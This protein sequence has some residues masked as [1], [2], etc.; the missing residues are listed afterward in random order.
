MTNRHIF[1]IWSV[2]Y[3]SESNRLVKTELEDAGESTEGMAVNTAK[4]QEKVMAL[5][6]IDGSGGIDILTDSGE[7]KSTYDILL[8][9]SEVWDKMNDMDQ[10]A[11]LELIAGKQRGS[12]VAGLLQNGDL[13][14]SVYESALNA[15]GSAQKELDTYLDSIQGKV[16]TLTNSMQTMWVNALDSDVVKGFLDILNIIVKLTDQAGLMNVAFGA[17]MGKIAF[18]SKHFGILQL[19]SKIPKLA[20]LASAAMATLGSSFGAVSA[21]ATAGASILAGVVLG[22]LFKLADELIVTSEEI[23]EAANQAKSAIDSISGELKNNTKFVSDNAK[24]FAELA[25]G[26]DMLSGKNMSLS[27][28]DYEEFLSLS[29]Q[30]AEIFP[31]LSR[32]YDENGNAIVQLSG[33]TNTMVSSLEN[34]LEVQRQ[35]AQQEIVDNLPDLYAGVKQQSDGYK[36]EIA[37]IESSIQHYRGILDSFSDDSVTKA[38]DALMGTGEMIY[39]GKYGKEMANNVQKVLEQ[40]GIKTMLSG[41]VDSNGNIS[42]YSLMLA[43]EYTAEQLKAAKSQISTGV[44]AV[45]AEYNGKLH[46]LNADMVQATNENKA[47]WSS[48]AG[49]IFSWL[50]TDSSYKILDDN[51]QSMVQTVINNLDYSTLDFESWDKAQKWISENIIGLFSNKDIGN[52][53]SEQLNNMFKLKSDFKAGDMGIDDYKA[54]LQEYVEFVQGLKVE[55]EVQENL[56]KMFGLDPTQ[57][58]LEKGKMH[59]GETIEE[60]KNHAKNLVTDESLLGDLTYKDL[61]ILYQVDANTTPAVNSVQALEEMIKNKKIELTTDFTVANYADYADEIESVSSSISTYQEALEKLGSGSF[62]MAD[63]VELIAKFPDLAEGVD[64]ASENFDGLASNLAKAIKNAPDDLVDELKD[65]KESLRDAGKETDAIDA[66]IDALNNM[67]DDALD[68]AISKYG[69]LIDQI[70][71]AKAA[72]E[73]LNAAMSKNPNEGFETRGKAIEQMKKLMEKDAIGSESELWD[74]AEAYGF[75]PG[76]DKT[77][78]ENAD[79]LYEFIQARES[80]FKTDKDGN[81]TYEGTEN[82][83]E[84][85]EKAIQSEEFKTALQRALDKEGDANFD[86]SDYIKWDYDNGVFDFDF[87]NANWD[88]IVQALAKTAELTGLTSDEFT[89]LLIQIGMFFDV[90]WKNTDDVSKYM[91]TVADG[92]STVEEKIDAM[93][94]A[95]EKYVEKALGKDID[96]DNLT[97][98]V[99]NGLG[100]I[101]PEIKQL[102]LDYLELKKTLEE[103]PLSIKSTI[104]KEGVDGLLKI[105][106]LLGVIKKNGDGTIAFDDAQ[107][108]ATLD[109]LGYAPDVIDAV[110]QKIKEY[111][112]LVKQPPSDPLGVNDS[113]QTTQQIMIA[114]QELGAEYKITKSELGEPLYVEANA[115]DLIQKLAENGWTPSQISSYMSQL[116]SAIEENQ[117][118]VTINGDASLQKIQ[119][120]VAAVGALE[121]T[122]PTTT[123]IVSTNADVVVPQINS[124]LD[125]IPRLITTVHRIVTEYG[126]GGYSELSNPGFGGNNGGSSG[127][128]YAKADGTA[129]VQGTAYKTGSWG[130]ENTE[131]ALVGELGPE[132]LV[133][134]G[135]WTTIGQNG[136]EFTQIKKGDIIFNHKQTE[137]LL[138][139]GYVAGRGRAYAEGTAFASGVGTNGRKSDD[140]NIELKKYIKLLNQYDQD[141]REAVNSSNEYV[142]NLDDKYKK[143]G[144]IDNTD[145]NIVFWNDE[146]REKHNAYIEDEAKQWGMNAN[147]F[148][149]QQLRNTWSTVLGTSDE[150]GFNDEKLN[151]AYSQ[152]LNT[153][154]DTML[155]TSDEIKDYIFDVMEKSLVDGKID[156]NKMIEIDAEGIEKNVQGE[157]VR[158]QNMLAG[159]EGQ[160][161]DG[162]ELTK[163]DVLAMSG[164]LADDLDSIY[165]D[166]SMHEIQANSLFG[167]YTEEFG[168]NS[169]AFLLLEELSYKYG[170]TLDDLVNKLYNLQSAI[171]ST[172]AT[173]DNTVNGVNSAIKTVYTPN[174]KQYSGWTHTS[175]GGRYAMV[176]GTAH[177]S[178]TDSLGAAKT[179]TALVGELG[180]EMIVRDGRWT[181]VG[182]NGAEFRQIKKGDIIFNHKQTE[183]LLKNGYVTGRGKAYAE[184]TAF[185]SG[186]G[187]HKENAYAF[188]DTASKFSSAAKKFSDASDEF[189]ETFDW[190]EV[191]LEE[192][193]ESIDL[194]SA[195]LENIVSAIEKNNKIDEIIALN[196]T[197]YDNLIAGSAKY[198]EYAEKI[199]AD[200]PAQYHEA[201]KDGSIDIELFKG[202]ANE[203]VLEAIEEYRDWVQKGADATQ[204]AE[205]VITEIADLAKDAFDNIVEDYENKTSL[206]DSKIDQLDA[207]NA[208]IETDLG[209]ESEKIYEAMIKETSKNI[210]ILENQR[211][212]MQAELNKRVEAGEIQKHSQHWYDAVNEISEVD[213]Q[214][215]ELTTDIEDYQD[216]INELHWDNFDNL[217]DRLEMVANEADNLIDVLSSKD[218]VDKDTAEWTDEGVATLGLYAQQMEVAEMQAKKY[219]EE[220]DYLNKN[221]KKLGYTEQEY[222]EKLDELKSGQYDAIKSYNDTKEA[223]KDLTSERVDAIKR[224][225]E[226]E[227][228]AYEELI[229]KKKEELDAEKDLHDFQK[230]VADQQKEIADIERKLAA[231]SSDNSA[232]ARAQ[233]AK[234]QAE[235]A[236]A[237]ADL[238]EQYYERSI[239]DQ[240]NALDKEL[241]NFQETK[242]KEMEGWDEYL[243]DTEKVVSDSLAVVQENTNTVYQTLQSMGQEYSLSITEALTS[244][245]ADGEKAIQ[246]YSEKFGL[247]MSSTVEELQN[248]ATEYEKVMDEID[249]YGTNVV[250][251]VNDNAQIYQG[252]SASGNSSNAN[253]SATGL[254]SSLSGN[255][256]YGDTG[257][258]VKKLQQA[259]NE[260]GYGNSGTSSVD[261][262]FGDQT[263]SAVKKFQSAM[264]ISADGIV[265]TETKKKFKLKG[266]AN[267]SKG[268]EKD[269]LALID[270]LGEELIITPSNGRVKFLKKD[271]G[272][273]PADLTSNLM[274][275]GKLDPSVMLDQNRPQIGMSP[276]AINNTTEIHIDSSVGE[277]I[278][279]ENLN[280]NNPAEMTKII[281]KAWDKRMKELNAQIRRYASR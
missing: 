266:Y 256:K 99:V 110:I 42:S 65:L 95:V 21:I 255:I 86:I 267:G 225:I 16:N 17:L 221:W 134:D 241:E 179:E 272:V 181:T 252:A 74:I 66:L 263:L 209:T 8:A 82:F 70:T 85:A 12:V 280:G 131:T 126:G 81:V 136:A 187:A 40:A 84:A 234:L 71:A 46:E 244:P 44:D 4:L 117:L 114:L 5:T 49:S 43:G 108:T 182:D 229:D 124:Y 64:A 199:L 163:E 176:N 170:M 150:F 39:D 111:N 151:I 219:K 195:K 175:G 37:S 106:E 91:Q 120:I 250:D 257:A 152:M 200:I 113:R 262:I 24:R 15:S 177:S 53:V 125:S 78:R 23:Q 1:L 147:D 228:E 201:V 218:L 231:L 68:G 90:D 115:E 54:K 237:Q 101:D 217:I 89:D 47:N 191:R 48:L 133:R 222:V 202:E 232:S 146:A 141:V 149:D 20:N 109:K 36:Q 118:N 140:I 80:W 275:W 50:Q 69:S 55:P 172:D 161:V 248:L 276:S 41:I 127:G 143:Y 3:L 135:R 215:I 235:L 204:Q 79:A 220:I 281:D 185:V 121:E 35:L 239:Q 214:I 103:D 258:N 158:V 62:T 260:L 261:G 251:Q 129:H 94:K 2:A 157:I 10:A 33:D 242:D 269:Q 189:E 164:D 178:G 30:L 72:Q 32:N 194:N 88:A 7:F 192:I 167:R 271:S 193:N 166:F 203:K 75:K 92:S 162:I 245:W 19:L 100:E 196:R 205:E 259:L 123:H 253:S 246:D 198:Y 188:S 14:K 230:G 155:L 243:E 9:I 233:R 160:L 63:F 60:M 59:L 216:S 278:H 159:V 254:I 128:H 270:E 154:N 105:T 67:P 27:A 183:S 148:Y 132:L 210:G 223:I 137:S 169:E 102:L 184:G 107:L 139:N 98:D 73:A 57:I 268:I 77:L 226:K 207:Y 112:S 236:K 87:D 31:T 277:L 249:S 186:G 97:E 168:G 96:F 130:A 145:R 58:D 180:P 240:Q 119:E 138:K 197:L 28:D 76:A 273:I 211:N 18:S 13:M 227:I 165:K 238:E 153:G 144:N 264:G 156:A 34:L 104:D 274:E 26:V 22:G 93:T 29:N 265:G 171:K 52:K 25:Q 6:N 174:N 38:I 173:Y 212:A 213:T 224:G 51:M 247:A 56:L 122:T 206:G 11:L 142:Q 190:I 45:R 83:I 116:K 61:Q 279:V 208:L